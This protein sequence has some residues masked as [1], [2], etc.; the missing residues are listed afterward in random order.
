MQTIK[1]VTAA[2]PWR[3]Q[4]AVAEIATK[5]LWKSHCK[6]N[7][8]DIYVFLIF[9]EILLL[10]QIVF[11]CFFLLLCL[12]TAAATTINADGRGARWIDLDESTLFLSCMKV[13][14]LLDHYR[15]SFYHVEEEEEEARVLVLYTQTGSK[16][17]LAADTHTSTTIGEQDSNL[18]ARAATGGG[19]R[20]NFARSFFK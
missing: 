18:I 3:S 14:L 9:L 17:T 19:K 5:R 6:S 8:K 7:T 20:Q 11:D 4:P 15:P 16:T 13:V 12:S 10:D 1:V 2:E